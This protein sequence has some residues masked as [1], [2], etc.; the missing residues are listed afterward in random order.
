MSLDEGEIASQKLRQTNKARLVQQK[1]TS[2]NEIISVGEQHVPDYR[3]QT[4]K[5]KIIQH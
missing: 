3:A 1:S 2:R 5:N 4:T